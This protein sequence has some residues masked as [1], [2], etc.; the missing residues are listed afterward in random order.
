MGLLT[1][2]A[3]PSAVVVGALLA[4]FHAPASVLGDDE[5][6]ACSSYGCKLAADPPVYSPA[7]NNCGQYVT[8]GN[9]TGSDGSC[10]C[11]WG[12]LLGWQCIE[13]DAS[14]AGSKTY[15]ISPPA[16]GQHQVCEWLNY[17][18]TPPVYGGGGY[19]NPHNAVLTVIGCGGIDTTRAY[20]S[21]KPLSG[22][23]DCNPNM[24]A[25]CTMTFTLK[26]P[27]CKDYTCP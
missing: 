20:I 10:V 22:P 13:E 6:P 24:F 27:A 12:E 9:I 25:T 23:A 3:Q 7:I 16:G 19:G 15:T 5:Q 8:E 1:T 21:I 14:C 11:D 26:C 18:A 17:P 4:F 2:L